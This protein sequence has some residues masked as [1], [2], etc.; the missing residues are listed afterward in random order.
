VESD[1]REFRSESELNVMLIR[2]AEILLTYA[3]SKLELNEIDDSVYDAINLVR[4]R[5][6]I[7]EI[8]I[9]KSQ[10]ELRR[11]IRNERKVEFPF[12]G[13]RFFDIRRWKIAEDVLTGPLYGRPL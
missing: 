12:E 11:I 7:P 6:G 2:Y 8:A 5:A 9:G 4:L 10:D 1:E 13:I 3:E